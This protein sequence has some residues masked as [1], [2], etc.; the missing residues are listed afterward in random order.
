MKAAESTDA[1]LEAVGPFRRHLQT[2]GVG[3]LTEHER[4]A[5]AEGLSRLGAVR[6]A[7]LAGA[8]WPPPWWHHDGM[9]PLDALV[10]WSDLEG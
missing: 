7:P 4:L 5:L 9:G 2:V 1:I 8:P 10:R 3:G 6:V